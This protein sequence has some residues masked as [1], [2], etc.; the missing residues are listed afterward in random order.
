MAL[1]ISISRVWVRTSISETRETYWLKIQFP[2]S[3]GGQTPLSLSSKMLGW[4][5]HPK[6]WSPACLFIRVLGGPRFG[7]PPVSL[8]F[9]Y[10]ALEDNQRKAFERSEKNSAKDIKHHFE[11][12]C[13]CYLLLLNARNKY[14][15]VLWFYMLSISYCRISETPKIAGNIISFLT[16]RLLGPIP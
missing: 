6:S 3:A 9:G 13:T 8:C 4:N 12:L 7:G 10:R 2:G 1:V 11:I 15:L 16:P 5:Y 14:A